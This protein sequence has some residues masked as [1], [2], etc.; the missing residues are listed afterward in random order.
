[1]DGNLFSPRAANELDVALAWISDE[2]PASAE[3]LLQAAIG[4]AERICKNPGLARLALP[5][6]AARFRFWSLRGFPYLLV[7]DA[8]HDPPVIVRFVHQARDLPEVLLD[9]LQ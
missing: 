1:L 3:A 7:V 5:L 4:A 9:L 2:S 8:M 6:A